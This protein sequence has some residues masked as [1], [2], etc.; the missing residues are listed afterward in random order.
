MRRRASREERVARRIFADHYNSLSISSFVA[1]VPAVPAP[2]GLGHLL[3]LPD[4]VVYIIA[5]AIAF[6]LVATPARYALPLWLTAKWWRT[7]SAILA[8][9]K[10][11][12]EHV[13]RKSAPWVFIV[14]FFFDALAS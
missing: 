12:N 13:L 5:I 10:M 11:A 3:G 6:A 7:A 8:H 1:S 9:G 4:L 14:G 2:F